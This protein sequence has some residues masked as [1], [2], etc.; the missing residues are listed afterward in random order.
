MVVFNLCIQSSIGSSML[1]C[2]NGTGLSDP[3]ILIVS[4]GFMMNLK[5][6][7]MQPK[8]GFMLLSSGTFIVILCC[9]GSTNDLFQANIGF[10]L[11]AST[12]VC[13]M[14]PPADIL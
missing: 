14:L 3:D 6:P 10:I 13:I 2:T 11:M 7:S 5:S 4:P 9:G 1:V 12:S 8:N